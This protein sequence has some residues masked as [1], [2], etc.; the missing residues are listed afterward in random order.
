VE[1]DFHQAASNSQQEDFLGDYQGRTGIFLSIPWISKNR[2]H[3]LAEHDKRPKIRCE[4]HLNI[5]QKQIHLTFASFA[6]K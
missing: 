4:S 1:K 5:R 6:Y 2:A 3:K